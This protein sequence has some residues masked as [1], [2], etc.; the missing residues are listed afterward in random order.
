MSG[1]S[2]AMS[3]MSMR[4]VE[5]AWLVVVSGIRLDVMSA[6]DV[7]ASADGGLDVGDPVL[8]RPPGRC[9]TGGAGSAVDA[10]RDPAGGDV[11]GGREGAG[12][13]RSPAVTPDL[14]ML[15]QRGTGPFLGSA[16]L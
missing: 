13:H 12:Q 1:H 10:G 4:S 15:L 2:G 8:S 14:R 3:S 5:M 7:P 6:A 9:A 11:T 16:L